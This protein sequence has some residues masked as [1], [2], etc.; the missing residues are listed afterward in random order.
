MSGSVIVTGLG[1]R[2]PIHVSPET[3]SVLARSDKVYHV[4]VDPFTRSWIQDINPTAE[5]YPFYKDG[6]RRDV[7]AQW[8]EGI[9]STAREGKQVSVALYG[10]PSLC[11]PPVQVLRARADMEG[12]PFEVLPAISS[13]DCLIA[14]LGLDPTRCG[15]QLFEATDFLIRRRPFDTC[16]G[17]LLLQAG[18]IGLTG[19]SGRD[20][21]RDGFN[22][23]I[24]VLRQHYDVSH[25]IYLYEAA[26]T[27]ITETWIGRFS[28][29]EMT[30][31]PLSARTTLFSPPAEERP[32][33][34]AMMARLG[35][36]SA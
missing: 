26:E 23:L 6:P 28:L 5:W 2:F 11:V 3:T 9:L 21:N 29:A 30:N 25:E 14:D 20:V 32:L 16:S 22:I 10:H 12:I 19:Y 34:S 8:A 27:T 7:S 15:L 24:E 31:A 33:D 4:L 36:H 18:I 35:L 1:V 13:A 17:V